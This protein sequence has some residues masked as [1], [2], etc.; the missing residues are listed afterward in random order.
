VL[1]KVNRISREKDV[2]RAL[3]ARFSL[4]S[5]NFKFLLQKNRTQSFRFLCVVSKKISKKANKR[6]RIKRKLYAVVEEYLKNKDEIPSYDCVIIVTNYSLI[7][8][9]QPEIIETFNQLISSL[10]QK[11]DKS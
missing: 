8:K 9:R 11:V 3:R 6:N 1:P 4:Y 7:K 2:K 5:E 10:S